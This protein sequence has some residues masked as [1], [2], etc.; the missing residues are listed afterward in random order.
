VGWSSISR[1]PLYTVGFQ[2]VPR[3]NIIGTEI[4]RQ[5]KAMKYW[6]CLSFVTSKSDLDWSEFFF[7]NRDAHTNVECKYTAKIV[8][9]RGCVYNCA[10][11]VAWN[12]LLIEF[13]SDFHC[14]WFLRHVTILCHQQHEEYML[15]L[16]FPESEWI[17]LN[18]IMHSSCSFQMDRLQ[19][20]S[21]SILWFWATKY[22]HECHV[23]RAESP[24]QGSA[25]CLK[26]IP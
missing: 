20:L 1:G 9:V 4:W 6:C 2:D 22:H 23:G 11:K 7:F 26:F 21:W 5:R 13:V 14:Y 15:F 16:F 18:P 24:T 12:G 17:T 25:V 8:W 19:G 10:L 3:R